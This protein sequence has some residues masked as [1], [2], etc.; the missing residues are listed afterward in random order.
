MTRKIITAGILFL[1]LASVYAEIAAQVA[2]SA[3]NTLSSRQAFVAHELLIRFRPAVPARRVDQLLA[4]R[5][6]RRVRRIAALGVDVLRLPADLP[7]EDAVEMF[8]RLPEVEFAEPNYV[9]RALAPFQ[10]I[11][12]QWGLVSIQAPQAW[13]LIADK[14]PVLIAVTDTGIDRTHSDVA[15]NIWQNPGEIAGDGLDNDGNGYVDDTWGWDFVNNDND[16]FDDNAHGTIV[17]SVAAGVQD[18]SGVAGVCPWCRLAS[19]KVLSAEGTGTLDQVANGITY[20]A[21]IGARVINLSLAGSVGS[22]TLE[23]A[24]NYAWSN[25][26]L[27][28]AG[29]GNDG[30]EALRYPAAYANA[31]AIASTSAED[32]HSCFSNYAGGYIS[33]AAPGELILSAK[34]NQEYGT[35]SGTSLSTPHVAGLGGLLFSQVLTRTNAEVRTLIESTASD[36]G[37]LGSDAYFGAGRINALRAVTGDTTPAIPPAG[38]FSDDLTASGYGHARK[39]ARDADGVLHLAW[40]SRSGGS[41]R[42]LYSTSADDGETWAAPQIVF[43]SAVETFHPAL[44]VDDAYAYLVF[45]SK[46][47]SPVYRIFFTR[48][49]LSGGGWSSP[50]PV[51]DSAHNAVR[52]D[53]YL[54]LSTGRLHVAASSLDDA[55]YVYYIAADDHGASWTAVRQVSVAAS[56]G[57][58]SRYADVHAH[59]SNVYIAARTVEFLFFGLLPRYRV[60]TIRSPNG[61]ETWSDLT[62]LAVHD[63]WLS[64]EYGVSLAGAGDRLY[65]GYEHNGGIE[66]RRSD[67]GAAWSS[68]QNIGT[69]A[70]PSLAQADDGRAWLM[71]ESEGNL[72]LRH[73][74]GAAWNTAET[75]LTATGRS[76][77]YYPNLKLGA[78]GNRLEWAATHCSGAPFRLLIGSRPIAGAPLDRIVY[79]PLILK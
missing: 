25:G 71:W 14:A 29:A 10:E 41:Y 48:R 21:D 51:T 69:G 36:L 45:P 73:Y 39:L 8:R 77:G 30:I 65:L 2:T 44:A 34:P 22:L 5:D 70:W 19:V 54:D 13:S 46:E 58:R 79:L 12:D 52:P 3:A 63:G 32:Y 50:A 23:N 9:L 42:V 38:L 4:E 26:A 47:G 35:F 75:V 37:P 33:V 43:A 61:G 74:T 60:V 78:R 56:D 49:P 59:G 16:P 6:A 11:A 66:F 18:G 67:G 15:P 7:V 27:V 40:H 28:V 53:V 55:R 76:K 57:P 62:E 31:M 72:L 24:V 68:A 17:G 20:A 1:F 64:G